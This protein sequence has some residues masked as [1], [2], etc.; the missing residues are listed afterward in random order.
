VKGVQ[1]LIVTDVAVVLFSVVFV[2]D[3]V[4]VLTV[5]ASLLVRRRR[6]LVSAA[7]GP[8]LLSIEVGT[9][10]RLLRARFTND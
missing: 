7:F 10:S 6:R 8:E 1:I 9:P 2:V 3:V 4:D 5:T